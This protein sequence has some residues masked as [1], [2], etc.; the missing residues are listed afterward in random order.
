MIIIDI[1]LHLYQKGNIMAEFIKILLPAIVV[2][3]LVFVGFGITILVK[4]NGKFPD[5]HIHSNKPLQEMGIH[6]VQK[7]DKLEQEK[8]RKKD[9]YRNMKY[10]KKSH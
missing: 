4:R 1:T 8:G 5:T 10:L 6:C 3:A 7:E 9:I 2:L